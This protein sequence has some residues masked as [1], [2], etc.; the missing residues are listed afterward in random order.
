MSHK[1]TRGHTHIH[2]HT[3]I[4][5]TMIIS[6]SGEDFDPDQCLQWS[7]DSLH[8]EYPITPPSAKEPRVLTSTYF[9]S[10]Y[11]KHTLLRPDFIVKM[12]SR[13]E[14]A[15][16]SQT[17]LEFLG[18]ARVHPFSMLHKSTSHSHNFPESHFAPQ[19]FWFPPCSKSSG[20]IWV[21]ILAPLPTHY[22]ILSTS[23]EP[24]FLNCKRGITI[25]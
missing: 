19:L 10:V 18:A 2:T 17:H 1:Y 8:C 6:F 15:Q 13:D 3:S 5:K 21:Q 12:R 25:A 16:V 7:K 4:P 22:V 23:L 20:T 14:M 11:R 9:L 24:Y